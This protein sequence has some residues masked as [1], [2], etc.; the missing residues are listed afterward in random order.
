MLT[1][2]WDFGIFVSEQRIG[3]KL[4]VQEIQEANEFFGFL[5]IEDRID[6]LSRNVGK[7]LQLY[8]V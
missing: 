2:Y 4:K 5:T 6:V 3:S 1:A 8:A 7:K